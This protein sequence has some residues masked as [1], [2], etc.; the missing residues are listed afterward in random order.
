MRGLFV[1]FLILLLLLFVAV[2]YFM[3][4]MGKTWFWK[5]AIRR[6]EESDRLALREPGAIVFT[7]SSSINFWKT[8]AQEMA[9]LRVIN[10]GF[11]G[12]HMAHV[13]HFATDIVLP[14]S[15][16]AVVVYAGEN[17]LCK[18]WLKTPETVLQDFREFVQL[19]HGQLPETWIYFISIKPTP[20]RWKVWEK[21]QRTNVLVE[22]FCRTSPRV[23]FIDVSHAMLDAGGKPSRDLFKWDGLHPSAR[24]Y[25]LWRSIIHPTLVERFAPISADAGPVSAESGEA[26]SA[27]SHERDQTP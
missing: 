13:T 24:C 21:Q 23:Q 4:A 17:D 1:S 6:F 20:L 15:P 11:G 26:I 2:R 8:L 27:S 16:L 22:E 14:Y 19:V 9:P 3:W 10:R 7:G 5:R 25:S 12:S 18:P